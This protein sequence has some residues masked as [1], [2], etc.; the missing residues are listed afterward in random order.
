MRQIAVIV[1]IGLA[2]VF[3]ALPLFFLTA[4]DG[5]TP[6]R[7][8]AQALRVSYLILEEIS[9]C[10]N[11]SSDRV[12]DSVSAL[13]LECGYRDITD[14]HDGSQ[15]HLRANTIQIYRRSDDFWVT[16]H[17]RHGVHVIHVYGDTAESWAQAFP[18]DTDEIAVFCR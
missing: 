12:R 10:A 6:H 1:R 16:Y 9:K 2:V 5:K 7:N 14:T 4:C 15:D 17:D 3:V 18:E 8:R 11:P 13:V